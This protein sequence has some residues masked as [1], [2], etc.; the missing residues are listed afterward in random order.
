MSL[1]LPLPKS[2]QQ[3]AAGNTHPGL[4]LDKYVASWDP[5]SRDSGKLQEKIQKPVLEK[6]VSLSQRQI[7]GTLF[8]AVTERRKRVLSGLNAALFS[9][10]T[11]SPLSMHLARA[12]SL[13][14]AGICLHPLYGFAYLPGS[15]IKG[16]A[17]AYAESVW[18]PAQP[19]SGT[20]EAKG[21]IEAVFGRSPASGRKNRHGVPHNTT[22]QSRNEDSA[23]V[24][25]AESRECAGC[26][27]FHDAWPETWPR[28]SVDIVNNHHPKYYDGTEDPGD[29]ENPIPVYFLS[30]VPGTAFSFALS[31]RRPDESPALLDQTREWLVGALCALGAGAK[32]NAGYGCFLPIEGKA[33]SLPGHVFE[34]EIELVTPAF[35]AGA[36]QGQDDCDLRGATLR[37]LF[38]WWW[39]TLHA[40][41]LSRESLRSVEAAIWGNTKAAGAVRVTVSRCEQP[42]AQRYDFK[43]RFTPK[44]D[45]KNRNELQDTPDKKTTQGLFYLSYGMDDSGRKRWYAPVGSR[46][47]IGLSA[48]SAE[49]NGSHIPASDVLA[50]AKGA[51]WL[52]CQFGGV[53]SKC[54][55]G[56]GSFKFGENFAEMNL[57]Q[58]RTDA[59]SFRRALNLSENNLT[60]LSSPSLARMLACSV[61]TPWTNY[62]F[63]LDQLGFAVQ[64]FSKKHKHNS[65]KK[66]LGLPRRIGAP[67]I[68]DFKAVKGDRHA[69]PVHF[70]FDREKTGKLILQITAFPS[71]F[72]PDFKKSQEFIKGFIDY[73]T[74]EIQRRSSEGSK[75][76]KPAFSPTSAVATQS[77]QHGNQAS[78]LPKSQS[79]VEV[80]LLEEKTK[81]GGW[82]ARHEPSGLS[83][84]VVN[85][86][87]IPADKNA[88]DKLMLVVHSVNPKEIQFK[89][90]TGSE[91]VSARSGQGGPRKQPGGPRGGGHDRDGRR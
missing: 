81:K 35:F 73:L 89:F 26:V 11:T 32:T 45:F 90:P 70:H 43:D 40:G 58:M 75:G 39:R 66:A 10:S 47:T 2:M 82:K 27:V 4:A 80:V 3:K 68:G 29:W 50:Q 30:V 23:D 20:N 8:S 63:A 25:K 77:G 76:L 60:E 18:L 49:F 62:W 64:G 33:P 34:T 12:A 86:D 19:K 85:H 28:L 67:V 56:F 5:D 44:A 72:L 55:K 38:R 91:D 17:R 7:D 71:A 74:R 36:M 46:W 37:G 84:S 53:G 16:M 15:G 24:G 31:L 13:E 88:G 79:L 22:D 61:P 65:E 21:K 57:D 9:C 6:V 52:L 59:T 83:G 14:N 78:G 87:L 51:L 42:F 69:S 1:M 48:R 54:R 41:H